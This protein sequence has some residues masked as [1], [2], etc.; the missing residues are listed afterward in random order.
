[1]NYLR[2]APGVGGDPYLEPGFNAK[3]SATCR[4]GG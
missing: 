3:I 4:F 1:V 2:V